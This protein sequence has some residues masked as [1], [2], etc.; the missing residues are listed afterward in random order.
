MA[1]VTGQDS[2]SD[3]IIADRFAWLKS[4]HN[5]EAPVGFTWTVVVERL[6]RGPLRAS[7]ARTIALGSAFAPAMRTAVRPSWLKVA[8]G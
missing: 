2:S 1:R 8:P 4:D 3:F 7:A 5:S 6:W